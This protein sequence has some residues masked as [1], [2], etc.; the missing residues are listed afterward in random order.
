[1]SQ[2]ILTESQNWANE[3]RI[4][5]SHFR[6]FSTKKCWVL[7]IQAIYIF[8]TLPHLTVKA[9]FL[10][11]RVN[12]LILTSQGSSL[13]MLTTSSDSLP[14][15]LEVAT[16]WLDYHVNNHVVLKGE[17]CK[18]NFS[19]KLLT[20]TLSKIGCWSFT[21]AL[22]TNLTNESVQSILHDR[23]QCTLAIRTRAALLASYWSEIGL[24]IQL[25]INTAHSPHTPFIATEDIDK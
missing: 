15:L 17:S 9:E 24:S 2:R 22:P 16:C 19:A 18:S 3:S 14:Q 1:M 11:T 5:A 23:L 8:L 25:P 7:V 21:W 12:S 20:K 4:F 13:K 6:T 10:I